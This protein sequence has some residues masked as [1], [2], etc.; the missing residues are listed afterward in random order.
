MKEEEDDNLLQ[1]VSSSPVQVRE[2]QTNRRFG[3]LLRQLSQE[4][5]PE[6]KNPAQKTTTQ[7]SSPPLI[8]AKRDSC[9]TNPQPSVQ[10]QSDRSPRCNS[11]DQ[12]HVSPR[13]EPKRK[14]SSADL[15]K[16]PEYFDGD[17]Y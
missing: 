2:T 7:P 15:E 11:D 16:Q 13:K 3:R 8:A 17:L 14:R 5:S 4:S 9:A 1:Q 10:S 12:L 6:Q